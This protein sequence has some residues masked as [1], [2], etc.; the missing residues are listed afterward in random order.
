MVNKREKTQPFASARYPHDMR[1]GK[2]PAGDNR[3]P[4]TR[5]LIFPHLGYESRCFHDGGENQG[6]DIRDKGLSRF[7]E[8]GL[9]S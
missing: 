1:C 3:M 4:P 9:T 7:L 6:V 2:P 5:F 8:G